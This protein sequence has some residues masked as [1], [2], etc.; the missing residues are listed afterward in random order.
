MH[1]G[2]SFSSSLFSSAQISLFVF[3]GVGKLR[4][5]WLQETISQ[6]GMG[7]LRS[8]KSYIDPKNIFAAGNLALD[9]NEDLHPKI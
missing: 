5:Q 1:E 7:M 4:K 9:D 2:Y 8:V 6:G 3:L